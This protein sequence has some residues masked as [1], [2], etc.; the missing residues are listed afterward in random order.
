MICDVYLQYLGSG[1]IG[2][3]VD[4]VASSAVKRARTPRN[5]N[6]DK[7]VGLHDKNVDPQH[8]NLKKNNWLSQ[9]LV[10]MWDKPNVT[11]QILQ[12]DNGLIL[13]NQ[14]IDCPNDPNASAPLPTLHPSYSHDNHKET[15][16]EAD[17]N[18][19]KFEG[20]LLSYYHY[21]YC[22]HR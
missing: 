13:P 16:T 6:D 10:G 7:P 22:N 9:N 14:R 5:V 2:I 8:Q 4:P 11:P 18:D 19:F 20:D 1:V 3:Q 12:A 15:K 21:V 17:D